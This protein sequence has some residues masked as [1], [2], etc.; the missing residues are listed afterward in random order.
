[1]LAIVTGNRLQRVM[2]C[3]GVF[4]GVVFVFTPQFLAVYHSPVFF[5]DNVRYADDALILGLVLLPTCPTL[6]PWRRARWVLLSYMAI[7]VATQFDAGHLAND[8][9]HR[10]IRSSGTGL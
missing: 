5:V 10:E 7:L 8:I 1:M 9:L 6:A 4:S 3:V 2:G